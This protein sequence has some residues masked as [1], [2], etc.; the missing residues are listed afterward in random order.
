MK[1]L[2]LLFAA[3][4]L[5]GTMAVGYLAAPVEAGSTCFRC[6]PLRQTCITTTANGFEGCT[7]N[8][9]GECQEAGAF[10]G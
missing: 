2:R 5:L 9:F 4:F 8:E 3:L 10:C 1:K 6:N 7:W